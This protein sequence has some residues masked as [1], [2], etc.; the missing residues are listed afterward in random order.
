MTRQTSARLALA[1]V[2]VGLLATPYLMRRFGPRAAPAA[3]AA[4]V[5]ARAQYGFRLTES[6]KAAG[7]DFVHEAPTLDAKLAH[8]MPQV[9]SMGAAVSVGDFDA[10]GHPDLY[11]T[12]SREG[13]ANRLFRNRGDGTFEDVAA[14]LNVADLNRPETGVSMG[15]VW[16]DYDNDGFEDLLIYRWGRAELFHNDGGQGFSRATD[17]ANLPRWA[18]INTAVWFDY[19]RDG[20]I[21]IFMGGYY[22]ETVNLWKLA[23]T[24]MMPESF[25][26]ANNGGRKY[27]YRNLGGGRFEEVSE[28]VGLV[29]RRW[30]LAAVAADLRGTG[31]P[32]LFIANDYGVSELFLNEGGHFRE[33]GRESGVGIRAEERDERVGGRRAQSEPIRDLRVEHLRRGDSDSGQQPV[34]AGRCRRRERR[35]NKMP[36][37]ENLATAMGVDL[38]GWSFG[39]QFGDLNNDGF[40]DLY[41]VNGYVSASREEN[42]WYDYSKVAGGHEVVISDAKNWPAMGTRSLAGYQQKKVWINDGAGRFIDVAPMVGAGD[43]YDGRA[44]ALADSDRPRRARRDRRQSARTAPPLQERRRARPR[45]DRLRPP[46]FVWKWGSWRTEVSA[47]TA[48]PSAPASPCIGAASSRPRKCPADRVSARRISAACTSGSGRARRFRRLWCAGRRVRSRNEPISPRTEGARAE[49][50]GMTSNNGNGLAAAGPGTLFGIDKRYLAP[51][52]VTIVL[53]AGQVTFGF[54]ESWSRTRARDSH[55]DRR[56]ARARTPLQRQMAASR[57]R[58]RLRHQRRHAG[59]LAG[60]LAA[61]ALCSAI[62]ITSKYVIRVDGRHIWNPSNLGI[63]AMLVLA[64]DTVA[65]LSVQWGNTLLPM[66]VVWS[67]GSVI[68]YSLGRLHIT[69]TYVASFL[70]FSVMRAAITGHPWLSEVAPITGPMYQL[71]IF[72]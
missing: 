67:F 48:A 11:V 2:F 66:V 56:R 22:P 61:C 3:P 42:Y 35:G 44:V 34:G 70:A 41:L 57:Q 55:G 64:A 68:L 13:S 16:G 59:A 30:A 5:D 26:Y 14:R 47:R 25:E 28:R 27:L 60:V 63:V 46:R 21:D 31:Y 72:S 10:D 65:G 43:R 7:L 69:A 51:I 39:A 45:L 49:G 6:A 19:D 52:L 24:K 12:N 32:D 29:S 17:A 54:L 23:D 53:V 71:F 9:A 50:T 37:Y 58:L 36:R 1:V 33:A 18:N 40:L 8:I 38:G 4:G 20:L 62:S 15:S